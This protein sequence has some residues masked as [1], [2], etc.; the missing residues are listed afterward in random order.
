MGPSSVGHQYLS[1]NISPPTVI[2]ST[3]LE[4]YVDLDIFSDCLYLLDGRF[5]QLRTFHVNID[6]II[7]R[8]VINNKVDYFA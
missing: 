2:S 5:N 7:L 1:F 8:F 4:L 6:F 3:L